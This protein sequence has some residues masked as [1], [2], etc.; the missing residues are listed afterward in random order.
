MSPPA[1]TIAQTS[2]SLAACR[3]DGAKARVMTRRIISI[4]PLGLMTLR[5]PKLGSRSKI[6]ETGAGAIRHCPRNST[7]SS[8]TPMPYRGSAATGRSRS[9]RSTSRGISAMALSPRTKRRGHATARPSRNKTHASPGEANAVQHQP[10]SESGLAIAA[11]AQKQEVF[12]TVPPTRSRNEA[13]IGHDSDRAVLCAAVTAAST[14]LWTSHSEASARCRRRKSGG[15]HRRSRSRRS[16]PE[17]SQEPIAPRGWRQS[18]ARSRRPVNWFRSRTDKT[19]CEPGVAG[20]PDPPVEL[21][22]SGCVDDL[23]A[24]AFPSTD[25]PYR[26]P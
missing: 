24:L 18:R 12:G 20:W 23:Q 5:A 22:F 26:A 10:R 11:G 9:T 4:L 7:G 15:T 21:T 17:T 8:A 13:V 3:T 19:A 25:A 2:V 6:A 1:S 14:T 16:S